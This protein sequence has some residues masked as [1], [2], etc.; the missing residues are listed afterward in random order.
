MLGKDD[1]ADV[2]VFIK[3]AQKGITAGSYLGI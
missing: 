2:R 1:V 3:L